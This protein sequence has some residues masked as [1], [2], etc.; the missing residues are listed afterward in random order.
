MRQARIA[1][2]VSGLVL[3]GCTVFGIREG[4]A[5]PRFAVL[6]A[7]NG[8]EIRSYGPDRKSVV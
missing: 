2:V 8:L 6:A 3:T 1:A 4:T 7:P 5:E